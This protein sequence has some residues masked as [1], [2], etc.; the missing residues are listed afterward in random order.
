MTC[1]TIVVIF[2]L[3]FF[4]L[5]LVALCVDYT[6]WPI[7]LRLHAL[8]FFTWA[9]V[10]CTISSVV[11][12]TYRE[13]DEFLESNCTLTPALI[14]IAISITMLLAS[15]LG[16]CH[17]FCIENRCLLIT[18]FTSLLLLPPLVLTGFVLSVVCSLDQT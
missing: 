9:L 10:L 11:I 17:S 4:L 7:I 1:F 16:C 15:V 3:I 12:A 2:V 18:F 13:Y 14:V 8:F 6:S 5:L